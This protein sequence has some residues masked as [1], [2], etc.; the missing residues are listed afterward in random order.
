MVGEHG[1]FF[2]EIGYMYGITGMEFADGSFL[3]DKDWF[4]VFKIGTALRSGKKTAI[5]YTRETSPL[6]RIKQKK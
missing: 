5:Y 6:S 3:Y 4:P 2:L 1:S